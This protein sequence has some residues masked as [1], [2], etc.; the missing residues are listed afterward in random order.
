MS[1]SV[2][3][4]GRLGRFAAKLSLLV[5]VALIVSLAGPLLPA[6]GILAADPCLAPANAI[7]AENCK[8]GNPQ[9]EWDVDGMGDD[10]IQGYA[11]DFSVNKGQTV[12]F[13]VKTGASKYRLDIYRMGYYGGNGARKVAS[14]LPSAPLPQSQPTCLKDAATLLVDCGNWAVSATWAVPADAASGIYFARLV[15]GDTGG[16]SH[17][18]FIVRDDSGASDILFQ[19]ADTTWQSYNRYGGS[20]LYYTTTAGKQRAYKV[21]YNRPFDTRQWEPISWVFG[22]EYPMVRFLERNGYNVSYFSGIDSDRYGAEIREHKTFITVGH[23]EYWS[24]PQRANVEAA[25]GAGVNLAFFSGNDVF[26]KIRW[27]NSIDGTGTPHKT[28]VCYKE[29]HDNAKTDPSPEWTGT[30]RDPRFSPP[31]NGGRPENALSGTIF[32][33]NTFRNDPLEV[34]AEYAKLRFWR[35]TSVAGLAPGATATLPEGVLGYEWNEDLDNGFRPA[36]LIRMS[37]TTRQVGSYILDYGNIYG[38]GTATHALTLY[39]HASG[40]LV[41]S[42]GTIQWSWGL[43]DDH[44]RAG[45]PADLRMQQATVNLFADMGAQP[46]TLQAGLVPA[47]ASTDTLPPTSTVT[48]P[49]AGAKIQSGAPVTISGTATDASGVVGGVEVSTDGGTTWHSATGTANWTYT[50]NPPG[51]GTFTI[52]TRATDDSANREA[53]SAGVTVAVEP[54]PCPCS[55]W[56]DTTVPAVTSSADNTPYELGVKFQSDVAGYVTAI[57]FYKGG[58]NTGTHLGHLWTA[59]GDMLAEATFT[60]ETATGWQ[61]VN[62]ATPVAIGANTTYIASYY[63]PTGHFAVDRPYFTNAWNSAP[64]H[65][66]ADAQGNPNGVYLAGASGFP[67]GSYMASNYWVDVVFATTLATDTTPP[68]VGA[69]TPAAGAT[70]VAAG[71]TVTATF[72]EAMDPAAL[73]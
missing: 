70:G 8:P 32:T 28:M 4:T 24:G 44:D 37:R 17:I 13:K 48:S 1:G 6:S 62:L 46:A 33:V 42:A 67:Y 11:A 30:W 59:D 72:S 61:Q 55:L 40:A 7:V 25:R 51:T 68:A 39:R 56:P 31:S 34:P 35:N 50:W 18:I 36:G 29:T 38:D 14:I 19:T 16:A 2:R 10:T 57:R 21:S 12:R 65:A 73:T 66:P 5:V 15:R 53:P 54:R 71:A 52:R 63:T 45:T 58:Q 26:W 47:S 49:A 23:D 3:G 64:L 43:D 20:S 9:T 60:S 27:E 69:T 41:F 22:A